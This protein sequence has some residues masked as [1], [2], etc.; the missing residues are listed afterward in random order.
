MV[1][2]LKEIDLWGRFKGV[3]LSEIVSGLLGF[4]G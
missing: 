1:F 4:L 3:N 2:F